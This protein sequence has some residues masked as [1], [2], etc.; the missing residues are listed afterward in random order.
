M[1]VAA[2]YVG[3]KVP[4]VPITPTSRKTYRKMAVSSVDSPRSVLKNSYM[5]NTELHEAAERAS[6]GIIDPEA[7]QRARK[8]MDETREKLRKKLGTVDL[9]VPLV[10]EDRDE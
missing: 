1:P 9:A 2:D 6:K 8:R 5:E 10:R 3:R 7:A 4:S